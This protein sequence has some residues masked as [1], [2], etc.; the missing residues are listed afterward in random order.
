MV[1]GTDS[2][3]SYANKGIEDRFMEDNNQI[4]FALYLDNWDIERDDKKTLK[5][6]AVV[7][8]SN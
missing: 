1:T 3:K 5:N 4:K 8:W 6:D 7:K 2:H